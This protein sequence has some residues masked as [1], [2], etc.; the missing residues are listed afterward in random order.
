[1]GFW[2]FGVMLNIYRVLCLKDPAGSRTT[3][4]KYHHQQ[5]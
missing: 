4:V 2:G 3:L 5:G 1:M